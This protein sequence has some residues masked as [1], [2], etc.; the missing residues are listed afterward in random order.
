MNETNTHQL[1]QRVEHNWATEL[2]WTEHTSTTSD[3]SVIRKSKSNTL[4]KSLIYKDTE[5]QSESL[6]H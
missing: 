4:F 2:N 1:S 3:I 5:W 6:V